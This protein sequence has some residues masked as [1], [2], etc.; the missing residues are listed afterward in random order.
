[1]PVQVSY[2][3]VYIDEFAPGA[4]IQGVGTSTAAFVGAATQG[5]VNTPTRV[6]SW[7]D[8][9][10]VFGDLPAAGPGFLAAG[11]YGFFLNGGT[12]C[13]VV[14]V[15]S[16]KASSLALKSRAATGAKDLLVATAK[17]EGAAGDQIK[18][19]VADSTRFA[20]LLAAG[21][22]AQLTIN[23][24]PPANA[25]SVDVKLTKADKVLLHQALP[26]GTVV[27]ISES[28]K[29][30][31]YV[32]V[33]AVT[34]GPVQN[35]K[36]ATGKITFSPPLGDDYT[37]AAAIEVVEFKL[38]VADTSQGGATET[39]DGLS[40][41]PDA[42]KH[43]SVVNGASALVAVAAAE[44][45]PA[46]VDPRPATVANSPLAGGQNDDPVTALSQTTSYLGPLKAVDEVAIV[47]APGIT[48]PVVQ[49]AL[50]DHCEELQ[51][52]FAV[53]DAT[54]A[55]G[56]DLTFGEVS[57]QFAGVRS[58]R[59]YA[60]LYYPWVRVRHPKTN[61][62]VLW[63]PSGHVAGLYARTDARQGVHKAP[64]NDSLRGTLGVQTRLS[65]QQHGVLNLM[66]VNVIR[67][68]PGQSQP[69]V[70]GARTT[71][72]DRNWQYVNIRRLFVYLEES[73]QEGIRWAVFEPNNL[74]LWQKLKRSITAFLEQAWRD[75]ALFGETADKAFYVRIDEALNPPAE[76]ALGR[77][78]I[79]IGMQPVYPAEF[80][81]V[82][83]GIWD[84]GGEVTE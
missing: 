21:D 11:V 27:K 49:Q 61:K 82:R 73:I 37:A 33:A 68:L 17:K 63:P 13:F 65:D 58:Q 32:D 39:Y 56:A 12:D 26:R 19:T 2:P 77:L 75:G 38:T 74:A 14:R 29:K 84:G 54:E 66:G 22:N 34:M 71:A 36:T 25:T 9:V 42:P 1:M 44:P 55:S 4:P 46:G 20:A 6:Q 35:D 7:D 5:P 62:D 24:D 15:G 10:R 40:T 18:V 69:V 16:G 52:R 72:L 48:D 79:E 81:I 43:W 60:A 45:P 53:L 3:G 83:I 31:S 67:V 30:D 70:M 51:D 59:G 28:N 78:Y 8:F 47:C 76:R 41:N 64:A 50:R 80:I 57:A 23:A